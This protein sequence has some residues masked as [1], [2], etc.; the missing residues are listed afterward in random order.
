M[1]LD[2]SPEREI[3]KRIRIAFFILLV[4]GGFLLG[5]LFF[6][7]VVSGA[8][9]KTQ[10]Q[11]QQ[12]FSQILTPKRGDIYLR[13]RSGE[14]I[15]VA[16]TKEGYLLFINP[17][18]LE[19]PDDAFKKLSKIIKLDKEDF[20]DRAS[21]KDDP[22]EVVA[23][24]LDRKAA[25]KVTDLKLENVGLSPEEW[26]VYP[27]KNVASHVVG[28]LGYKD[29]ELEGQYGIERFFEKELKGMTGQVAGSQSA[30]GIL[31]ELGKR[32]FSPPEE[33]YD[34]VLTLEPN[35]QAFVE[36]KLKEVEEAWKPSGGGA[37]VI[38]PKTGKILAM[39]AFP[40]FDPNTYGKSESLDVFINPVVES[41]FEF[42]SV[43]K[44][45]TMAAGINERVVTPETTYFDKGYLTLDG[46]T[47]KNFDEK[48]RGETT[49]QNVLS[50]S[51]NTGAAFV[52]GKLGKENMRRYFGA[53]GLGEKTG[54]TLPGEVKGNLKNLNSMLD[55]EYATAAFGQGVSATPLEFARATS[56][57]ANGGKIMKPYIIERI[58]RPG[59][60]D[61]V[62]G[63]EEVRQIITL[64]TAD[65]ISRMLV[66]VGDEA[67]LG[68]T[69]KFKYWT[70]AAKTGTA[71][72]PNKEGKG[73]SDQ[74]LHSFLAYAPGFDARF[75]LFMY[76]EKPQGV[77]YASTSLGPY[78]EQIMQ[79]LLTYYD[80]PPDR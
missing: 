49:M 68:G 31:L 20:L 10:A 50:E 27:A 67:L 9:Y 47:I 15:P 39:A 7:Q 32:F 14:L 41:V 62:F 61:I 8:Y 17:K 22:Y 54:I 5:R 57:L 30:G 51:L 59:R 56:A 52:A 18:K 63:P 24:R 78:Y 60:Q 77:R 34:V 75:L 66:K 1:R 55:I 26:R 13:E 42:G 23:H 33:G 21:K 45:L 64:E 65:T 2:S 40:N 58:L 6:L 43:F 72:I 4:A 74:Y 19:N 29:D 3:T 25:E 44:P 16:S 28:F 71:E 69:A 11:R 38:E 37:I 48:G 53:Y 35:V 80:V 70:A 12:N 73:Y 46:Y 36:K 79:F 76:I